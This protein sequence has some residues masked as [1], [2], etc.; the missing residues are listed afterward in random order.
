[1]AFFVD[2]EKKIGDFSLKVQLSGED[3]VTALLGA[4]GSGK[5]MTLKCIAGI[6]KP[7]KGRIVVDGRTLFDSDRGTNLTP[8]QRRTGLLFQN[9]A[10]FPHMTVAQNVLA[11]THR[12]KD[13]AVRR[14][15]AQ[16]ILQRFGLTDLAEHYPHQ[17]SGGEQQR[18]ALARLLVS[19][20]DILLLDEPFSAL[21]SHLRLQMEQQLGQLLREFGKS[22]ILVSHDR[23]EV[24]R[25][26][27]HVA[28]LDSGRLCACG[29]KQEV[30]RDPGTCAAA[31]VTGC[32]NISRAQRVDAAHVYASDWQMLLEVPPNDREIASL[33]I[34]ARDLTP[35][36]GANSFACNI[37][38][39]ME[40]PF[41]AT[42]LLRKD[43][44]TNAAPIAWEKPK[45]QRTPDGSVNICLP[46]D[47][48]LLLKG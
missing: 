24:Y 27:D 11:G 6:E 36:T 20:P 42:L 39:E 41:S 34:R 45:E 5:S 13:K 38:G 16:D 26:A 47:K 8:R 44:S 21:D 22:A 23:D 31:R 2:V 10:L 19:G 33:G 7:D 14:Q 46:A 35:G 3:C 1:M 17:L 4:S 30:F 40:N 37:T 15:M 25:L 43:G 48:I 32:E 9:Y 18:T 28:V 29:P 12:E